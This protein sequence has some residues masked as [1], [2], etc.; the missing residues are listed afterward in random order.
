MEFYITVIR[1]GSKLNGVVCSVL[2]CGNYAQAFYLPFSMFHFK[3]LEKTTVAIVFSIC[4]VLEIPAR[5]GNGLLADKHLISAYAQY[6]TALFTAGAMIIC[7]AII[8]GLAGRSMFHYSSR[9]TFNQS[10]NQRLLT[11]ADLPLVK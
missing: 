6:M 7:G 11:Y 8:P 5:L 4:G 10:I 3:G 1:Q 9:K 2:L